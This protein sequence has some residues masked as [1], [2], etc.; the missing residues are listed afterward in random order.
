MIPQ[1]DQLLPREL[2]EGNI[3]IYRE[4]FVGGGAMLFHVKQNYE[5]EKAII[6]DINAESITAYQEVQQNVEELI[7]RLQD[8][9]NVY[10]SKSEEGQATF[11]YEMRE[12]F[13]GKM[14]APTEL[15]AQFIFL[16]KTCFNG[17]YRV[18]GKGKFNV[19]R[20]NYVN[21][22]ICDAGN[23]RLCSSLLQGV[24]IHHRSYEANRSEF[25]AETFCY[26]D[27]PY[28]P[29]HATT[30]FTKYQAADFK[31]EDQR[32]LAAFY[33]EV[34]QQGA[35]LM[36]SNSDPKSIYP[37]DDFFELNYPWSHIHRVQTNRTINSNTAERGK[38]YHLVITND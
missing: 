2:K 26:F 14:A 20:G 17:L 6:S 3:H 11:Y 15:A 24:E 10:Y 27:P 19:P 22:L 37:D 13:N 4:P 16:N 32:A 29:L 36:L 18:N 38:T 9:Q 28:R 31:E 21:P 23:L 7:F 35:K 34:H 30:S 5:V 12:K 8:L 25:T 33:N 1:L